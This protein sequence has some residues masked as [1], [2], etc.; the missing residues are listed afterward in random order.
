M[1]GVLG[2]DRAARAM[3]EGFPGP[4]PLV[5]GAYHDLWLTQAG[6]EEEKKRLGPASNLPHPWDP[7]TCTERRLRWELWLWL[8][9]VATWINHEYCWEPSR[10]PYIPACWPEHPHIVHEL[11]VLADQRRRCNLAANSDLLETWHHY[12]LPGFLD[13]M[14][15]RLNN[16]CDDH[17]QPWP[18]QGRH[19]AFT[20]QTAGLTRTDAFEADLLAT[21]RQSTDGERDSLPPIE[22]EV[23][24]IDTDTGEVLTDH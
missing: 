23:V 13:R 21:L 15:D 16:H 8:D 24:A 1:S 22:A 17:H 11:A 18:A 6:T 9:A 7:A 5:S 2:D 20:G 12:T 19:Q 10:T 4:G 3:V 14:K